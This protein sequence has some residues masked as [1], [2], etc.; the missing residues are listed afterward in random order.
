[1]YVHVATR[2]KQYPNLLLENAKFV[3]SIARRQ[4]TMDT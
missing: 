2:E 3:A 4:H 1:M